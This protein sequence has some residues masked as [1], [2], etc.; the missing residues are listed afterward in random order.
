ML[1]SCIVEYNALTYAVSFDKGK[2]FTQPAVPNHLVASVPYR[3]EP[4]MGKTGLFN[5]SNIVQSDKDG[6]YYMLAY[7]NV[8]GDTGGSRVCAMRTNNLG[9]PKSWRA[10]DGS[11]YNLRFYDPY[12]E[13]I[14]NPEALT[15]AP[16]TM[17]GDFLGNAESLVWSTYYN[18]WLVTF[19][20]TTNI[21]G[22]GGHGLFFALS[23]DLVH[24]SSPKLIMRF[25]RPGVTTNQIPGGG[26]GMDYPSLIDHTDASRNFE[27]VGRDAYIYYT[28][29]DNNNW[30]E[31]DLMRL[32]VHFGPLPVEPTIVRNSAPTCNSFT[33]SPS[34]IQKG[35][36]ATLLWD[37]SNANVSVSIDRTV[38]AVARLGT[39]AVSPISDTVYTLTAVASGP[40]VTTCT[41]K[42][43]V[44][45]PLPAPQSLPATP[46][47]APTGLNAVCNGNGSQT[48]L[49]WDPILGA[50]H[51][52][53]GFSD[54]TDPSKNT[55]FGSL[56]TAS[57]LAPSVAGHT[58]WWWV[59]GWNSSTSSLPTGK[60]F[61]C[62]TTS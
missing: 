6:Y 34:I 32:P 25:N 38:S 57:H 3:Y 52:N 51:Y 11:G 27:K 44:G 37:V 15:C 4:Q 36:S 13:T 50:S 5:S 2:T 23:D 33:V 42:L 49:T 30:L 17:G 35:Q 31:R 55:T 14:T 18:K 12:R 43:T 29:F 7:R 8:K 45:A 22:T 10:W 58:Y 20:L 9:N 61:T 41:T 16:V 21:D 53:V 62:A 60:A 39:M 47:G 56:T 40:V 48:T 46:L 1:L 19:S 54:S 24:W 26:E 28:A 59:I